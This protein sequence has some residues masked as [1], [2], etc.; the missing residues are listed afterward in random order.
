MAGSGVGRTVDVDSLRRFD[1]LVAGGARRMAGWRLR[2]LDLRRRTSA[3]LE[4]DAHGALVLGCRLTRR[5]EEHL[6][7][8]GAIVFPEVPDAPVEPYRSTLYT[9]DELYRDL[10]RGYEATP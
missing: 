10:G 1:E 3:L 7:R 4:L 2:G 9:A 8:H 6:R 5:G